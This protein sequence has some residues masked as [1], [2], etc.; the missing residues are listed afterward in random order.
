MFT[1]DCLY[2]RYYSEEKKA[3][4]DIVPIYATL[5][6]MGYKPEYLNFENNILGKN[7]VCEH[8]TWHCTDS[9]NKPRAIDC[10][11]NLELF[12]AIAALNDKTDKYQ[13]FRCIWGDVFKCDEDSIKSY[14]GG[15]ENSEKLSVI[16][17]IQHFTDLN[18]F[19][20]TLKSVMGILK[21]TIFPRSNPKLVNIVLNSTDDVEVYNA[22]DNIYWDLPDSFNIKDRPPGFMELLSIVD[23]DYFKSKIFV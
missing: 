7:L 10:E 22:L 11:D 13:Y 23:D 8:Q 17:L 18:R 9:E 20:A 21:S 2:R 14:S 5:A 4:E 16:E 12:L 19:R 3:W 6:V 1:Q 15:L